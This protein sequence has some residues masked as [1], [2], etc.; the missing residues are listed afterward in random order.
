M[1]RFTRTLFLT[2]VAALSLVACTSEKGPGQLGTKDDIV[3][4]NKGL[5]GAQKA[6]DF[7]STTEQVAPM[8]PAEVAAGETLPAAGDETAV[9]E[10]LPS[11]DPAVEAA[12]QKVEEAK[13]P[14][15]P[16][17]T[18]PTSDGTPASTAPTTET[19]PADVVA[20][21]PVK[22]AEVTPPQ[23]EGTATPEEK[24]AGAP[25][26]PAQPAPV[27]NAAPAPE[28]APVA[29]V[30]TPAPETSE[31]SSAPAASAATVVAKPDGTKGTAYSIPAPE[32]AAA[33]TTAKTP[34]PAA[35]GAF[36]P[37]D[38]A[39]IKAAQSALATK[40]GYTG[41]ANGELSSEFLNAISKYQSENGL[42]PSGVNAETLRHLGVIE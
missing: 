7:S 26:Y 41:A 22:D 32:N 15:P 33:A 5:P 14:V 19:V 4:N 9:Q 29:P 3:V 39:V 11:T 16:T 2:G 35:S 36:N 27:A 42:T 31:A 8:P 28:A 25:V 24:S 21:E 13:A 18:T 6:T 17:T 23:L 38:P 34:A 37:Y 1:T 12:A 10:P 40:A 20:P 30:S